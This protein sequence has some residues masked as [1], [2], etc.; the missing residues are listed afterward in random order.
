MNESFDF[1]NKTS[2][3]SYNL[4][5][6]MRYQLSRLDTLDV[7]TRKHSE[8]V[9]NITCRLCEYLRLNP[10]FTVYCTTCAYLH[11][12]GKIFIPHEI[13]QKNGK[14]TPEEYEIMKT[15]AKRGYDICMADPLL[16]PY[17]NGALYHHEALNGTGYPHG[18]TI[19]AIPLEG[20]IIR[21]ADEYDAIV[22]KRQYKSHIGIS[23]TLKILIENATPVPAKPEE[24]LDKK[25]T[26]L[27][28]KYGKINK[29]I[30][31]QLFKIVIDDIEYEITC[32]KEYVDYLAQQI[33]RLETI[34][35][36]YEKYKMSMTEQDKMYY[37][38]N[39]KQ[40]FSTGETIENFNTILDDYKKAYNVRAEKINNLYNEINI[41]KRLK[42]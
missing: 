2:L 31:I 22:N 24:N 28:K 21:V 16:K 32:V 27:R 11:D 12:L 13:L 20:Q 26:K 1:Y 35:S 25:T 34:K 4:N 3:K 10:T 5:E 39:I 6:T 42:V 29:K 17:A 14:L 30:L 37:A 36:Y 15:H 8:S 7:F 9:A 41:I 19:D 23:D 33:Q 38:E 40:L 18:V